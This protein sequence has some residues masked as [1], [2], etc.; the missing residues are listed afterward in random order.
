MKLFNAPHLGSL[1]IRRAADV[2]GTLAALYRYGKHKDTDILSR[3]GAILT[4]GLPR[5][6][7]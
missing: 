3:T 2:Y 4:S 7:P 1:D 5:G 6:V